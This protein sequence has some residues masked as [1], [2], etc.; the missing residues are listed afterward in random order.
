MLFI[1]LNVGLLEPDPDIDDGLYGCDVLN[2][3]LDCV[4]GSG[5]KADRTCSKFDIEVK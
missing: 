5:L 3:L 1:L 4:T 2:G